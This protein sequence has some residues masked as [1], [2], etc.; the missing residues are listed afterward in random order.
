[1][2]RF[3]PQVN[4]S[5]DEFSLCFNGFFSPQSRSD[6][7]MAPP[8]GRDGGTYR[9]WFPHMEGFESNNLISP[10]TIE[11]EEECEL[12]MSGFSDTE[13]RDVR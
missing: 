4:F 2:R 13:V 3:F 6:C 11:E 5:G 9:I 12:K 8:V 10:V 7:I 1:M